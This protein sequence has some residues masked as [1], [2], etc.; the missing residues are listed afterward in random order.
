MQKFSHFNKLVLLSGCCGG[1]QHCHNSFTACLAGIMCLTRH[2][3]RIKPVRW[4]AK[5]SSCCRHIRKN[6]LP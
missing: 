2:K 3:P 6:T 5:R 4:P 1:W